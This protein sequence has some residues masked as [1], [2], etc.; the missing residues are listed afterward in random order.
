[1]TNLSPAPRLRECESTILDLEH[2]IAI[3]DDEH[4]KFPYN[5]YLAHF[6]EP[7]EFTREDG[8]SLIIAWKAYRDVRPRERL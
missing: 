6:D 4:D 5:V 7:L 2:V 3:E 1:M 8:E